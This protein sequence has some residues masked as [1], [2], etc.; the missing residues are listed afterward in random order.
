[1]ALGSAALVP[2][3]QLKARNS[4]IVFFYA[5]AI[6]QCCCRLAEKIVW[7]V[8]GCEYVKEE[9]YFGGFAFAF[10]IVL[11]LTQILITYH[12]LVVV[13]AYDRGTLA[14]DISKKK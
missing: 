13:K 6:P 2:L 1:M 12:L 14:E 3:W 8:L 4:A 10:Y 9:T 11:C 7:L 5:I